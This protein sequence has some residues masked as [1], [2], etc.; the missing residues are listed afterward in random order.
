MQLVR[1]I[2]DGSLTGLP[3][4]HQ[5]AKV[6]TASTRSNYDDVCAFVLHNFDVRATN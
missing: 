2:C 4:L 3:S 5:W 6:S 1:E